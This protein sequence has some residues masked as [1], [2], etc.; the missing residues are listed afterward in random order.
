LENIALLTDAIKELNLK[1]DSE[2]KKLK[3]TLEVHDNDLTNL[4]MQQGHT[5][6][7][8]EYKLI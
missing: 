6:G 1:I 4:R 7:K 3:T 8:L 5:S 2:I